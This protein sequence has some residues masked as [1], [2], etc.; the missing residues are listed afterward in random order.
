[1][2]ENIEKIAEFF[3]PESTF[4]AVD[5]RFCSALNYYPSYKLI[6]FHVANTEGKGNSPHAGVGQALEEDEKVYHAYYQWV[7][8]VLFFQVGWENI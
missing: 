1:L 4:Q 8:F 7:P 5:S 2:L 3:F 6:P